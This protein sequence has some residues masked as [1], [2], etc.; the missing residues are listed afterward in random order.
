METCGYSGSSKIHWPVD[1]NRTGAVETPENLSVDESTATQT[2][3][4]Q[5]AVMEMMKMAFKD[6][7]MSIHVDVAGQVI[8]S[9]A[10]HLD[11]NR[12]TLV[13]IAFAEFLNSEE[14]M[15]AMAANKDQ[16]V[17]DMK[18]IMRLIPGLKME[19]EPEVSVLL[20]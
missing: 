1:E 12:V 6:M 5:E 14:V 15:T 11:G 20:E 18:D 13:D 17:A 3:E 9:N 4:Q 2:P 19:I 8:D 16:T 10:T 7:R